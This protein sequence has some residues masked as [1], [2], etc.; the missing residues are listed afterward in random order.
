MALKQ[1]ASQ[2]SK[3]Q[4]SDLTG[5]RRLEQMTP[6]HPAAQGDHTALAPLG[7]RGSMNLH[8]LS[9]RATSLPLTLM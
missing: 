9:I 7:G 2:V 8:G 4:T 3:G 1:E 6:L 5:G